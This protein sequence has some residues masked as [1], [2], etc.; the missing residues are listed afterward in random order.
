M[1]STR[2]VHPRVAHA[3]RAPHVFAHVVAVRL[4]GGGL[5][6]GAEQVV[7]V[8][9]I[10]VARARLGDEVVVLEDGDGLARRLARLDAQLGLAV[11]VVR[12]AA[13]V[14]EELAHGDGPLLLREV[15]DVGLH[16]GVEVELALLGELEDGDGRHRL[17]HRREP[18]GRLGL[19][20]RL[21]FEVGVAE[22]LHPRGA[23][24]DEADGQ[25]RRAV[26]FHLPADFRL[27]PAELVG[28][29]RGQLR[30]ARGLLRRGGRGRERGRRQ[31][32]EGQ[33]EREREGNQRSSHRKSP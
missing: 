17:R 31:R 12:D 5:D 14:A 20:R 32:R 7:A 27:E 21:V 18:V 29:T 13:E 1:I 3:E 2:V 10:A 6:D 15:G 30:L 33:H 19:H 4:A 9:R 28:V 8:A 24:L 22:A 25:P 11:D 26:E 16:F 23:V